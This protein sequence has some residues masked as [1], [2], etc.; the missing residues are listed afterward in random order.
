VVHAVNVI[1]VEGPE[2]ED[3]HGGTPILPRQ[4]N[5]G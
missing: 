2:I 5:R 1:D 4:R 3:T